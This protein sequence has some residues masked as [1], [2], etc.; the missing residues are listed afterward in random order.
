MAGCLVGRLAVRDE[1][2]QDI[3]HPVCQLSRVST[4][5]QSFESLNEVDASIGNEVEASELIAHSMIHEASE[6][7]AHSMIHE[8]SELIAHSIIHEASELIAH[9]IIHEASELIAHS[10][11]PH[12][13]MQASELIA[14]SICVCCMCMFASM[15]VRVKRA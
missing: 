9:S 1:K 3:W 7:I 14:H 4:P 15:C 2:L 5:C 12:S 8:A 11:I 10:I 13:T 6:L